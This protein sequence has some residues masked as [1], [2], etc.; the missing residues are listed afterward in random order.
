[1]AYIGETI[2]SV[3]AQQYPNLQHIVVDG[4]STDDTPDVLARYPHL[5]VIRE[6]DRGQGDAINKGFRVADGDI[7]CF[8]NSD[9]TFLPGAL[10]RVAREIDPARGRHIVMGRC[11]FIDEQ[12]R[13]F[14]VEHPSN[15]ESFERVLKIW[16]GHMIPQPAVFWTA[17]VW[18][19]CGPLDPD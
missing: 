18:K 8:L 11:R 12:S 4:M 2:E 15:F 1:G 10:H 13:Y 14:G 3:L 6:P 19:N 7:L 9:D 16:K 17:E 5:C